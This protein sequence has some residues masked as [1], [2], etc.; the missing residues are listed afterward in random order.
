MYLLSLCA[1]VVREFHVDQPVILDN[2]DLDKTRAKCYAKALSSEV[3]TRC[4]ELD[5]SLHNSLLTSELA[6]ALIDSINISGQWYNVKEGC[7]I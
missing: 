5:A 6:L 1:K 7:Y 4:I 2:D 3:D